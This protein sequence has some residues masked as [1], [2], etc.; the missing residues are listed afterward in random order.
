MQTRWCVTRVSDTDDK[1]AVGLA[2]DERHPEAPRDRRWRYQDF[3]AAVVRQAHLRRCLSGEHISTLLRSGHHTRASGPRVWR[4][5][6][7]RAGR[8]TEVNYAGERRSNETHLS[9]T[10]LEARLRMRIEEPLGWMKRIA[11]GAQAALHRGAAQPS[12]VHHGSC[13]GGAAARN[14]SDVRPEGEGLKRVSVTDPPGEAVKLP[15]ASSWLGFW[16]SWRAGPE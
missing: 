9:T 1:A 12:L 8:N 16:V 7:V 6:F 15:A 11:A 2:A 3:F 14:R 4:Q 5:P 13:R 10:D